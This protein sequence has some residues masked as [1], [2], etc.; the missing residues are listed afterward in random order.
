[1]GKLAVR[2]DSAEDSSRSLGEVM[3]VVMDVATGDS[4]LELCQLDPTCTFRN[5]YGFFEV[6]CQYCK[7]DL[8]AKAKGLIRDGLL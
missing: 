7:T 8:E 1:M 4:L 2:V 5:Q 3:A 6:K